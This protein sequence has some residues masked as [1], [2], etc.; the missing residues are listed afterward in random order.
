M[1]DTESLRHNADNRVSD[2]SDFGE[3]PDRILDAAEALFAAQGY[4]ATS[5]RAIA[6]D[7]GV[8]LAAI[9]YH[10][11]SKQGLMEAVFNRRIQPVNK[12]RIRLLNDLEASKHLPTTREVLTVFFQPVRA[13]AQQDGV[14]A[15]MGRMYSEPENFTRPIM[16]KTFGEVASRFQRAIA[17][18][19]PGVDQ[20]DLRWRFHFMIGS[21]I[22]LLQ[23]SAPLGSESSTEQ[24]IEGMDQLLDYAAAGLEQSDRSIPH[25]D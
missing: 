25:A 13:F 12:E 1:G 4:A 5:I 24:F 11:G 16:Q 3:T 15:I 17:R 14:P 6:R 19:L 22:H 21:M 23:F 9:N 7:A 18:T 2:S 20:N 10:F 8:N